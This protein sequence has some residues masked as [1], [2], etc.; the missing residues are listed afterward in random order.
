MKNIITYLLLFVAASPSVYAQ[1]D[2][3]IYKKIIQK[4]D[5]SK[6]LYAPDKRIKLIELKQYNIADNSYSIYTTESNAVDFLQKELNSIDAKITIKKYPNENVGD[7]KYGVIQLSVANLRTKT[8]HDAEMATQVIMGTVVKIL[9]KQ[10][11]EYRIQTPEGY[12]AWTPTSSLTAMNEEELDNW[13]K[14]NK[15]I[16]TNDFGKSYSE[17]KINSQRV[18]DLVYGNILKLEDENKNF[19]KVA[20]PDGR[21]A[22]VAK[23]EA[24][25]LDKWKNSRNLSAENILESAKSMLG[26]PYLWGGTSVKGVDCSGFTKTAYYMN[27]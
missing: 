17:N 24:T 14:S 18:S 9:E 16:Y 19:Y 11:G 26:L 5:D 3:T 22:Y 20:Y 4:I 2:S 6:K 25:N 15:I 13:K 1:Q 8:G 12:I 10:K 7:K 21:K 23:Q 27:G